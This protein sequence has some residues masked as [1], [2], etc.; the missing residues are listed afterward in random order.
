[1]VF[2]L[3]AVMV[4]MVVVVI[5]FKLVVVMVLIV[6][7]VMVLEIQWWLRGLG[8]VNNKRSGAAEHKNNWED[9]PTPQNACHIIN[10]TL[11]VDKEIISL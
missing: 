9:N 11:L 2:K 6:V 3:K 4:L 5:V 1:M 10:F 8:L 7:V